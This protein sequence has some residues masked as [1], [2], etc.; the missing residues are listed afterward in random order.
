MP[1]H[2]DVS[3]FVTEVVTSGVALGLRADGRIL[4]D[5]PLHPAERDV[6]GRRVMLVFLCF[7]CFGDGLS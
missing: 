2:S 7:I 6:S 3:L 1:G 5:V 4:G